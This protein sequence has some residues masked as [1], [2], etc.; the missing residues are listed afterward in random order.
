MDKY[1]FVVQANLHS[2]RLDKAICDL[3]PDISRSRIQKAIKDGHVTLNGQIINDSSFKVKDNNS[4]EI[5]LI[6]IAPENMKP[7]DIALDIIYEDED[8]I[9]INKQA[10]LTVHPGAGN[11]QD[12]L[13]NALLYHSDNLSD[14]GGMT[15]PGIV[16][17]LDKDTTGLMVV[18]KNNFTHANLAAQLQDRKL[19]RKYK[20]LVWGIL[21]PN[22]GMINANIGRHP[23]DRKKMAALKYGGK[24]AITNYVT[25][26]IFASGL[27]SL[28][29][30]K[31]DTGR[32]HQIRVHL[33]HAG[34]SVVGD[35]VYGH[36]NRKIL[37]CPENLQ[38]PL[39][40]FLRQ[41]LHSCYLAFQHPKNG[42][43]MEFSIDMPMD[44]KNLIEYIRPLA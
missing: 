12:T 15:R 40:Q 30:C 16:H 22:D 6:D 42:H 10:G 37:Q 17:R 27:M 11:H 32:T 19:I 26:E 33:S 5:K 35:Q 39:E 4:L 44:M 43:L 18:A 20:A 8:L 14:I 24:I 25:E 1:S 31:L 9:V 3:L 23:V 29:E 2:L 28:I 7:A 41:A 34:H 13:A 36:N 38:K 21:K